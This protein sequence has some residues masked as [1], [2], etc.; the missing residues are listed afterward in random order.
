MIETNRF[1]IV[2][3]LDSDEA[4]A[5]YLTQIAETGDSNDFIVALGDVARA[6]GIAE[7]AQKTG[8]AR[9]SIYKALTGGS[10][11][12]FDTIMRIMNALN[13]KPQYAINLS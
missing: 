2:K 3:Y 9:E 10:K 5:I 6:K 7:I 4:I 12:R 11:P 1:D 8:L 13:L